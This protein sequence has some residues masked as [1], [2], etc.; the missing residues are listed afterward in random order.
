[1]ASQTWPCPGVSVPWTPGS[2]WATY[3]YQLHDE[4]FIGWKPVSF[5]NDG[6]TISI[7]SDKCT[8]NSTSEEKP[9]RQCEGLPLS[10]KFCDFVDRASN[11]SEFTNWNYLNTQQ[12]KAALKRFSIKCHDLETQVMFSIH[13]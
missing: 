8:D 13:L 4:E 12:L 3:P 1:M 11:A 2:V 10:A 6:K 9:C 5:A 7:R